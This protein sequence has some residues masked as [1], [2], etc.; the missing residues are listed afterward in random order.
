M[1]YPHAAYEGKGSMQRKEVFIGTI[2]INR[3]S[4]VAERGHAAA[5]F[6]L[7]N[8]LSLAM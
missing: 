5:F 1:L 7:Q 2:T 8:R 6:D 4:T 3:T